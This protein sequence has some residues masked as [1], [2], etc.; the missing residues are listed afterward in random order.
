MGFKEQ[1]FKD[2]GNVFMNP[3]EFG[4]SHTVDGKKMNVIVDNAEIIER[5]KKQSDKGRIEGIFARQLLFYVS[6]SEFGP[7]PAVGRVLE[8]DGKKYR[9]SDAV[10]EGALYSITLGALSS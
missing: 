9:I 2:I 3:D 5:S 10:D 8:F 7:L 4:E 1:L 6:R